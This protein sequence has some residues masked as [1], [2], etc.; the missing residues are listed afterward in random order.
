SLLV[1]GDGNVTTGAGDGIDFHA[2]GGVS[3]N[4]GDV[5]ITTGGAITGKARGIFVNQTGQGDITIT[6]SGKVVGLAGSGISAI[7]QSTGSGNIQVN[8]TGDVTGTGAG[9][10][11][12]LAENLNPADDGSVTVS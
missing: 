11:G 3:G 5:T 6:A 10:V 7:I 4:P 2:S 9:T 1:T 8:G 12:I